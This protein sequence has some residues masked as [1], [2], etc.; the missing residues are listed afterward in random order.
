MGWWQELREELKAHALAMGC[1]DI[2]GYN[3]RVSIQN[4]LVLL[5]AMGTVGTVHSVSRC[6]L[7]AKASLESLAPAA[8]AAEAELGALFLNM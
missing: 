8:S 7:L 3:E 1:R 4:E 2:M 5:S 6:E